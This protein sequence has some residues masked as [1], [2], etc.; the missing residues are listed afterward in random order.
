MLEDHV[1]Q[2]GR[3]ARSGRRALVLLLTA[4]GLLILRTPETF[5]LIDNVNLAIH[6]TGHILFAPFG[7]FMTALG[8][9]L[10]Q[11]IMPALFV[12]AFWRRGD[13]FAA[14][15][16][17]WWVAQSSWNLA[18]YIGDAQAQALPLVGGGEHDWAYLLGSLGW[19]SRDGSIAGAVRAAGVLVFILGM[20]GAWVAAGNRH[21]LVS[22]QRRG[23]P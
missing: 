4:Y 18:R 19:L 8:G 21:A 6:E 16:T 2:G 12:G 5:R 22:Q 7:E 9:S 14:Y 10:F 13:R 23:F 3:L 17:M 15:V 1:Q 20:L 11:L